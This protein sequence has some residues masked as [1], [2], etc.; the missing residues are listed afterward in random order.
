[1]PADGIPC[2]PGPRHGSI[3]VYPLS[4]CEVGCALADAATSISPAMVSQ[5]DSTIQLGTPEK[6][7]DPTSKA[8]GSNSCVR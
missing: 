6:A 8:G 2:P 5:A 3:S 7:F 1:M 4:S